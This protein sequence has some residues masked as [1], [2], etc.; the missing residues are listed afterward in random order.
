MPI[1]ATNESSG[2]YPLIEAGT[3]AARCYSM[4]YIGTIKESIKGEEKIM[5]KVRV[6]WEMATEMKEFKP[7]DGLKPT[8][9]SKE[10][11]LSM[12]EKSNLRKFLASWRGDDFSEEE[13]KAFD[14]TKLLGIACMIT[15]THKDK[16][17]K[18]KYAEITGVSKV[19]KGLNVAALINVK[20]ELNYDSFDFKIFESLPRYLQDKIKSSEEYNNM[21]ANLEETN[22]QRATG[23]FNVQNADPNTFHEEEEDDL[24][25]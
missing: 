1:I 14:V 5:K 4:I 7:G 15:I 8:V 3:Y 21:M 2:N 24:P 17:D 10:F 20:T 9:I 19:M 23:T 13:A 18:T 11:N 16:A 6:S 12:N 25:F 22:K